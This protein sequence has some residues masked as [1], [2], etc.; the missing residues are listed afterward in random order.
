GASRR[1]PLSS[2]WTRR[3]RSTPT[4]RA[5]S[6]KPS[7]PNCSAVRPR[8]PARPSGN[9]EELLCF[10]FEVLMQTTI[11]TLLTVISILGAD[12]TS[13][14]GRLELVAGGGAAAGTGNAADSAPVPADRAQLSS[15]FGV[16]FDPEG[17]LYFVELTGQRVRSIGSDGLVRNLAGTGQKGDRGDGG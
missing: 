2:S 16:A 11:L 15:P 8:A 12:D 6:S 5:A 10:L 3:V 7:F 17:I 4:R 14:S 1:F 9:V 13:R